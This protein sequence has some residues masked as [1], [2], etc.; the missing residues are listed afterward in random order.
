M[1]Q[2]DDGESRNTALDKISFVTAASA[3][4]NECFVLRA[5]IQ[6]I[7][8]LGGPLDTMLSG[9]GTN[10]EYQRLDSFIRLLSQRLE[11]VERLFGDLKVEPSEELYDFVVRV[12]EHV[13]R[14]RSDSKR[15]HFA[16]L[17]SGQVVK[18]IPWDEALIAAD[19]AAQLTD[20]HVRV[21]E[22]AEDAPQCTWRPVE[23]LRLVGFRRFK[24]AEAT[25]R[26]EQEDI[27]EP[28]LLQEAIREVP[29]SLLRFLCAD[30]VSKGLLYDDG[31]AR[32][33]FAAQE[34]FSVTEF[35]KSFVAWIAEPEERSASHAQGMK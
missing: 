18:P 23:G 30:L 8:V 10:W 32:L 24:G 3:R 17:L 31:V 16:N 33:D 14:D 35:G 22:V 27:N 7:P 21:L 29:I 25:G 28:V 6:G 12:F 5:G 1:G 13:R 34:L 20:L 11:E 4:Y 19:L 26:K 9:L 15:R 2:T